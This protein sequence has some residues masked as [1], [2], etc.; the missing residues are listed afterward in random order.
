[1]ACSETYLNVNKDSAQ[2]TLG[3]YNP[4]T[5]HLVANFLPILFLLLT[6]GSWGPEISQ[7]S[8]HQ[9]HRAALVARALVAC[10][11]EETAQVARPITLS[12]RCADANDAKP[13]LGEPVALRPMLQHRAA[14]LT[15]DGPF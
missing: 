10:L 1:M 3:R 6:S 7:P 5:T 13:T 11:V 9:P 4:K 2:T 12:E 8:H 15:R 14:G